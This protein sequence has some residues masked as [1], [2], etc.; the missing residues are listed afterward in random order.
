[1]HRGSELLQDLDLCRRDAVEV[2]RCFVIKVRSAGAFPS[3]RRGPLTGVWRFCFQSAYF[4][5][6]TQYCTNYPK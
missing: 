5:I 1:M 4:D 3:G 6:Y 2:A